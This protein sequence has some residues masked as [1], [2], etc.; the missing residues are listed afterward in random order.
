MIIMMMFITE[1]AKGEKKEVRSEGKSR[2]D[3]ASYA[4]FASIG[5]KDVV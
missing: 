4:L 3:S 1:G 5:G 2:E